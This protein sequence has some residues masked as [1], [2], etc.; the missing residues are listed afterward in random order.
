MQFIFIDMCLN[1]SLQLVIYFLIIEFTSSFDLDF[2][3]VIVCVVISVLRKAKFRGSE[4]L[5]LC[6]LLELTLEQY[7]YV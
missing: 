4:C 3:R 1:M 7:K 6:D 2:C 5:V